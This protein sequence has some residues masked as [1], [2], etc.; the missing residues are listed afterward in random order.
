MTG[1]HYL[2]AV[3][4]RDGV[5]MTMIRKSPMEAPKTWDMIIPPDKLPELR[6]SSDIAFAMWQ[7]VVEHFKADITNIKYLLNL[8]VSNPDTLAVVARALNGEQPKGWPGKRFWVADEAGKA[9]LGIHLYRE[10]GDCG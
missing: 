7:M 10:Q 9:L 1:A 3:N 2:L 4:P 8:M 6:V 5:I